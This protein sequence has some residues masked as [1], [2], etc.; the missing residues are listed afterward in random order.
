M[1]YLITFLFINL[2]FSL[3]ADISNCAEIRDN[4][5]RL[6]CFDSYFSDT[7]SND[8]N[9]ISEIKEPLVSKDISNEED[10]SSKLS[11]RERLFG[12]P[13]KKEE[14]Q[15]SE[16]F[17]II[18]NIESVS[19]RLNYKLLIILTN[20]QHWETVEKIRDIRLRD[21]QEVEIS[22]GF[23]SGYTLRVKE[24]KIKLRVRRTK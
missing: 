22:E 23:L 3:A 9:T 19:Q 13:E 5:K 17:K 12:L 18:S 21:N 6:S 15:D 14:K 20:G 8:E 10:V 7:K 1:K 4:E 2:S 11:L 24:K 16:E